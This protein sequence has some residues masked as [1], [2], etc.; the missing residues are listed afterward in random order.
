MGND[1]STIGYGLTH[2]DAVIAICLSLKDSLY[3]PTNVVKYTTIDGTDEHFFLSISGYGRYRIQIY[4]LGKG[5]KA[6][7]CFYG[8]TEEFSE[9]WITEKIELNL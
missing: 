5:C 4:H 2:H 6:V 7:L 3:K 8:H 9:S 1:F